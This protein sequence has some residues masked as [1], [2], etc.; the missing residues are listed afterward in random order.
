MY[1]ITETTVHVTYHPVQ[2]QEIGS[3]TRSIIGTPLAD[4]QAYVLDRQMH[5]LPVGVPG[6]LYI[7]G[8]GV[9]RGYLHRPE[10]TA[11]R[12]VPNPFSSEEGSRL[13]RTGDRGRYL[14]TGDLEYLGRVDQ[15]VKLRGFRI[16]VGEIEATLT[17][18]P[19]VQQAIVLLHE[20]QG[21]EGDKRL[22]AYVVLR[23]GGKGTEQELRSMLKEQLPDYM[24][25]S[26]FIIVE[27]LPLTTNGKVDRR[28]LLALDE[29]GAEREESYEAP[30]TP[31]EE[32]L[33]LIWAQVLGR[34]RIG[35]HD[36]FFDLGGHS[37]LATQIIV[38]I[39]AAFQVELPLRNMFMAPTLNELAVH[40]EEASR[41]Q[42]RQI[43][44]PPSIKRLPRASRSS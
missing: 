15:Q 16:E 33:A 42:I 32:A 28:A 17:E 21:D 36:N 37:L 26:S 11:E 23:T 4:L 30:Q 20:K 5:L 7:A 9:A 39:R 8:A 43:A 18:H 29:A 38:R 19:A 1:G 40:I 3:A 31:A 2:A 13:Y 6:E 41:Q 35:R 27:V 22:V 12:F 14:L 25:P 44:R 24:V 34:E 10:L